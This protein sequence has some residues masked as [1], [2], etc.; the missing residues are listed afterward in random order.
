MNIDVYKNRLKE[1]QNSNTKGH[2]VQN[3]PVFK[4]K[5]NSEFNMRTNLI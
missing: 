2:T 3:R 4:D 1:I 5:I